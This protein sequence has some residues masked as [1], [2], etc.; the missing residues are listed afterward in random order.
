MQVIALLIEAQPLH[1]KFLGTVLRSLECS[2]VTAFTGVE[3]TAI[4]LALSPELII[5]DLFLPDADGCDLIAAFRK[6]AET[7]STPIIVVTAWTDPKAEAK[8][9][10][11]GADFYLKKPMRIDDLKHTISAA[12]SLGMRH[13]VGA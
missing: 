7:A 3:G 12:I 8:C 11:V 5:M 1:A 9:L 13:S 10:S 4:A 2:A 6:H